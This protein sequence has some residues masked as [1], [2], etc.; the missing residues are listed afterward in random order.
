V[1]G[2]ESDHSPEI[3]F[4]G[5]VR[6]PWTGLIGDVA[7]RCGRPRLCCS[8]SDLMGRDGNSAG[9]LGRAF[10]ASTSTTRK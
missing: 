2:S 5:L 7:W 1:G 9:N 8:T 10:R 6:W 3:F 4:F